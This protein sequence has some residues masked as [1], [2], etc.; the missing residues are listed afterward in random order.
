M[1]NAE[2]KPTYNGIYNELYYYVMRHDKR[3]AKEVNRT[4]NSPDDS[5]V[6]VSAEKGV[7]LDTMRQYCEY[8]TKMLADDEGGI[9]GTVTEGK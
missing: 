3:G 8:T 1:T 9:V 4:G 2:N 5:Q 6:Y 7:G